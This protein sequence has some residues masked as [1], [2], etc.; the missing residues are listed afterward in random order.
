MSLIGP[1]VATELTRSAQAVP[2]SSNKRERRAVD[3][4]TLHFTS[5]GQPGLIWST[6]IGALNCT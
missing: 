5:G 3:I 1:L 6:E 2:V 4:M